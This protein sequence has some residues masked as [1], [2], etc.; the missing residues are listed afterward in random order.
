[1]IELIFQLINIFV[2]FV[3]FPVLFVILWRLYKKTKSV[4]LAETFWNAIYEIGEKP[5]SHG[6]RYTQ[7]LNYNYE[8]AKLN[9]KAERVLKLLIAGSVWSVFSWIMSFFYEPKPWWEL[10]P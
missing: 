6:E 1:M 4:E 10:I 9:A 5:S 3:Y 2:A 7:I 8:I